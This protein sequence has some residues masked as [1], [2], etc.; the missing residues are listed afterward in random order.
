M[1]KKIK[2]N[3]FR[4]EQMTLIRGVVAKCV[5]FNSVCVTIFVEGQLLST[6]HCNNQNSS[7]I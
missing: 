1:Y 4:A 5:V 2:E 3:N 7:L 6:S